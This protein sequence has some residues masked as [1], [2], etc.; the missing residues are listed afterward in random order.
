MIKTTSNKL[1]IFSTIIIVG[2]IGYFLLP[3]SHAGEP[4]KNHLIAHGGGAID[5]KKYTN[6]REAVL[7][8]I[9]NGF[10]YI[11][12]DL[13][14]TA[15]SQL[16]CM[17][18]HEDYRKMTNTPD[19]TRLTYPYFKSQKIYGKYTPITAEDIV[20][21]QKEHHFTLITDKISDP[22]IINRYFSG[23]KEHMLVEAFSLEDYKEL[24]ERGYTP[25]LSMNS[26]QLIRQYISFC[27]HHRGLIKWIIVDID[28]AESLWSIKILKKIFGIK[29]AV[30]S[31]S[32]TQ[33]FNHL[34]KEIDLL[35]IDSI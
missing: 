16:V 30:Y 13:Q 21:I 28:S 24:I 9:N 5:N 14:Y 18:S 33:L 23:I 35:Y 11:E 8:S 12:L 6:S 34:G 7:S 27:I 3:I 19:S 10:R 22:A 1:L 26:D 20:A 15:D 32:P 29:V 2:I 17:H 31:P 4:S 25:M